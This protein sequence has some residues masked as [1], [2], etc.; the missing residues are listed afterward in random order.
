MF[1]S[2][3]PFPMGFVKPTQDMAEFAEELKLAICNNR[4]DQKV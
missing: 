3:W 1:G 2:D 4:P